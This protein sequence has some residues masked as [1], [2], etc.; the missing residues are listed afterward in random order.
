MTGG[1]QRQGTGGAQRQGRRKAATAAL[2]GGV[3][4][5]MVGLAFAS[6]PLYRLFCQVTGYGGTTQRA[7][8]AAAP[9][10][11]ERV[12][13]VRFDATTDHHLPWRFQPAQRS[14]TL[15]VG[16][17]GLAFY[18]A[19]NRSDRPVTGRATFNV[20]PFKAGSYFVKID[21]FCFTE[22]TLAPGEA[23]DM[24]VTFYVDP[25][26]AE[27]PNLDDVKTITLSYTFFRAPDDGAG[28]SPPAAT[29]GPRS[30]AT[31]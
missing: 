13:T 27:D 11:G 31:N 16:E 23:V 22:Q 12:V 2:L 7:A 3:V 9:V 8:E 10:V 17:Q 14:V 20:T 4:A 30:D 1:A 5:G 28:G 25:A 18:R 26:I 15:R 21:C 19:E 24:P 6:V 29:P